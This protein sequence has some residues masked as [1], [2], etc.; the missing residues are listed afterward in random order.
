LPDSLCAL[1]ILG[2]VYCLVLA[3][4]G[5][6]KPV[7]L[8]ALAGLLIGVSVWLR[9]NALAM[10]PFLGLSLMATSL[11]FRQTATRAAVMT[12]VALLTVVP[13]TIRN[14]L[15]YRELVLVRI[16]VGIVMWEGMGEYGGREFGAVVSD[17][18][19][20][21]QEALWYNEPRYADS[22]QTPDGINRDRDRVKRSLAVI[23]QHP[24]WY[25]GTVIRRMGEMFNYTAQAPLVF[26]SSDANLR[27][28]GEEARREMERKAARGRALDSSQSPEVAAVHSLAFGR[29]ISWT[30]PVFRALQRVTKETL[31]LFILIGLVVVFLVGRRRALFILLVP[32]YYLLFQGTLHTEFRYTLPMQYFVFVFAAA[33]WALIGTVISSGLKRV[34]SRR[35]LQ[36]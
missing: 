31:L 9:P 21:R 7:W 29:S 1:P 17:E 2:A 19:V 27:K 15:L 34:L 11:N 33:T 13:I 5:R 23:V 4:R 12:L 3:E 22:W 8:Y 18:E 30:R 14:Y 25:S 20:A 26:R 28:A 32:L 6:R 16:G 10:A 24:L 36:G 35:P